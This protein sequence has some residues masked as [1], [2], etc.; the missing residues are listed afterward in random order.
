M[1]PT[2]AYELQKFGAWIA[3]TSGI[4]GLISKSWILTHKTT[5]TAA[6]ISMDFFQLKWDKLTAGEYVCVISIFLFLLSLVTMMVLE[7]LKTRDY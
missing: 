1:P 5:S 4:V 6:V 3:G 2:K 7:N